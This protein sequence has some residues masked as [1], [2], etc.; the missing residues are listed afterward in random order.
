M[1]IR[2]LFIITLIVLF[3]SA[4]SAHPREWQ[5]DSLRALVPNHEVNAVYTRRAGFYTEIRMDVNGLQEDDNGVVPLKFKVIFKTQPGTLNDTTWDL[6]IDLD[7]CNRDLHYQAYN[8]P[9]KK[10]FLPFVQLQCDPIIDVAILHVPSFALSDDFSMQL[11]GNDEKNPQGN[12]Q[13]NIID[14]TQTVN[15]RVRVLLAFYNTFPATSPA[16]ALRRWDGAHTGPLGERH[17]LKHLLEA[18]QKYHT[19]LFLLDL[20]NPASL[21]A[22]DTAGA[23]ELIQTLSKQGLLVLPDYAYGEK[24]DILLARSKTVANAFGLLPSPIYYGSF[25][26]PRGYRYT[27]VNL[28]DTSLPA[29]AG[30]VTLLPMPLED[31]IYQPDREG[32]SQETRVLLINQAIHPSNKIVV[33]GGDLPYATWANADIAGPALAYLVSRPYIQ[34]LDEKS[35]QTFNIEQTIDMS[36]EQTV[37]P[38]FPIFNSQGQDTGI[39]SDQIRNDVIAALDAAPSN[40]IT[41]TAWDM[42][43][44]L[45]APTNDPRLAQLRAQYLGDI[46]F[47]VAASLWVHDQTTQESCDIDIDHDSID[48]CVFA[49]SSIFA[50]F[51]RD[52]ARLPYLFMRDNDNNIHQLVGPSWQFETGISDRTSWDLTRGPAADPKAFP[53]AFVDGDAAWQLFNASVNGS[54]IIFTTPDG[55]RVKRFGF[56]D[57]SVNIKYDGS[58][59]PISQITLAIDPWLRFAPGW[60]SRYH[61]SQ[62]SWDVDNL[63]RVTIQ[64]AGSLKEIAFLDSRGQMSIPEDPNA[65]YSPGHFVPYPLASIDARLDPN[66]RLVNL[67]FQTAP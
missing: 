8:A 31:E 58:L 24:L 25:P 33:L 67:E 15:V 2:F 41:T 9:D 49:N 64:L 17:G 36:S 16:T 13:S 19:P 22:L 51:Q 20:K 59:P 4:C 66:T 47:L 40:E 23:T 6:R 18:A 61:W 63:L 29:H 62:G 57:V 21:S 44:A 27:F 48:D 43:F 55:A 11:S 37:I 53:G 65:A 26:P 10:V 30:D 56:S 52:G 60:S 12:W 5:T 14:T 42:F 39:K 34:L 35:L 45:T 32:I 46:Y 7:G 3:L 54:A 28:S 50:I 38:A 1:K